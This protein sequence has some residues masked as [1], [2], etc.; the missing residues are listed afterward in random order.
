[1]KIDLNKFGE[2]LREKALP[3]YGAGKCGEYVRRALQAAG[4]KMDPPY[5]PSGKDYGPA[6][7][8]LGFRRIA[9]S[10]PD[11]FVFMKGD[12]M[13]MEPHRGGKPHGHVA[14]FDGRHW[15][16]DHI[17]RDFW[18][19]PGYRRERPSYVVYRY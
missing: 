2:H 9:V 7:M 8:K 14:G 1:M 10:N 6:L 13:V 11:A 16:S 5:P 18:A 17:Q 4:A 12:V 15:I 19:G 3:P